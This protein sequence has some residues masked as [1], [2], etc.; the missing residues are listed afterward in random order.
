MLRAILLVA[1]GSLV[2]QAG[3][4]PP[5]TEAADVG[6]WDAAIVRRAAALIPTVAPWDHAASGQCAHDA[7][8]V[9]LP[10]AL[11]QAADEA[12]VGQPA[13]SDCH[14]QGTSARWEG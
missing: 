7:A 14:F 13:I 8:R 6:S 9:S 3:A 5:P 4:P 1:S 2:V 11:Q 10:C 12:G